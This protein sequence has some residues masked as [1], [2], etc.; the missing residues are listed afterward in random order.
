[1]NRT[2]KTL[3]AVLA[4]VLLTAAAYAQVLSSK[5]AE[6]CGCSVKT[7]FDKKLPVSHPSN[8]CID[9]PSTSVSWFAWLSGKS[10]S[11]Q[12]HYLDLLELLTR[13]DSESESAP[14]ATGA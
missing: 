9:S 6:Y 14:S 4:S 1:M 10:G 8:R 3:L 7:M 12:F 11:N 2:S 13:S 5:E